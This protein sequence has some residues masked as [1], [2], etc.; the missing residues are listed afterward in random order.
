MGSALLFLGAGL[1]YWVS[2]WPPDQNWFFMH[3]FTFLMAFSYGLSIFLLG[4]CHPGGNP[5]GQNYLRNNPDQDKFYAYWYRG[6]A[7][8]NSYELKQFRYGEMRKGEAIFV[9]VTE[10]FSKSKQVKLDH[11]Q[12]AGNDRI[13]V[14][15]LNHIRRFVTGI[16]DYSMMESIFTPVNIAEFPHS[17][18]TTTTSQDWCGHNFIQLNL[19]G[20]K[21]RV[22]SYSYFEE[23]GDENRLIGPAML[24]D[25]LWNRLRID[26][27][28]ISEGEVELIPATFYG[29]LQHQPLKPR[30]ARI[31]F[32]AQEA[33]KF[34]IV[35]YLHVDRTLTIGFEPE[36]PYKI[37]SW[38][39]QEGKDL[40]AQGILKESIKSAYWQQNRSEF[41]FLRDSLQLR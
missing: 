36:F 41:E 23:E 20:D 17:L 26:P 37:L 13:P 10:D 28:S 34:L 39:E 29:R 31:R 14:L 5:A 8:V 32:E 18:K 9:F 35:E 40:I 15:K 11:P 38:T 2:F 1:N 19:E 33:I 12:D 7:E 22:A 30:K 4:S 24:E 6:E 16:Y 27:S 21:Y 3:S 25:E